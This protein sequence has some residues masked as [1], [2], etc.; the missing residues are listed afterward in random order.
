VRY[1]P[2]TVASFVLTLSVASC[3]VTPVVSQTAQGSNAPSEQERPWPVTCQ[4]AIDRLVRELDE[5]S[6]A[7]VRNTREKDLI[8]FH[9]G[10]GTGIRNKYGM[11]RGNT[12]L[13]DSC[14]AR[15]A[16]AERH[17][18]EASMIIIEEVWKAL[19]R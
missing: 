14:I 7:R 10:W 16:G 19:Q 18:D 17:P 15:R 13:V 12:A 9:H 4:E 6:K 2:A 11:W 5:R 3:W 1:L 8:L